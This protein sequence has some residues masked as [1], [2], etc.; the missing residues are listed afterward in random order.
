METIVQYSEKK[1]RVPEV[2]RFCIDRKKLNRLFD[3]TRE[4]AVIVSGKAGSGKTNAMAQ[5]CR[6]KDV[7]WYTFDLSDNEEE[8]FSNNFLLRVMSELDERKDRERNGSCCLVMDEF[9]TVTNPNVLNNIQ[10]LLEYA[11]GKFRIFILTSSYMQSCFSKFVIEGRYKKITEEHLRF[12]LGEIGELAEKYFE[13]KQ[14]RQEYLQKIEKLTQGW[15]VAVRCLLQ[16]MEGAE[17]IS[18]VMEMTA[19]HL[20]METILYDYIYY[21]IYEKFSHDEQDFL[22]KTAGLYELEAVLCD[23]CLD[24]EDSG[25]RLHNFMRKYMLYTVWE[26]EGRYFR[27]FELFQIFLLEQGGKKQQR[28]MEQLAT[29]FYLKEQRYDKAVYHAG[30]TEEQIKRIFDEYGKKMLQDGKLDLIE[31]CIDVLQRKGHEFSVIGLEIAAEY[32]YRTGNHEQMERCLNCADSMF[33]KENKYGMYRSLYRALFHY[34]E[35][36]ERYAKQINEVLFFLEENKILL[37]Y[38]LEPDKKTLNRIM[39]ERELQLQNHAEKKIKVSAFGTFRVVILEDGKELSWRTRK[40]CELFAYL[41]DRNGEAVERKT[42]LSELWKEELPNNA[43]A[44]LHN[45]FYNIRKE[46]S[47]YN[48]E[49]IIQYKNKKY[50]MDV[51]VIESDLCEMKNA[52]GCVEKKK[53]EKLKEYKDLFWTYRG[54]YLEDIDN[55]WAREKQEY[56]EKIF[57][58]GCCMLAEKC[59]EQGEYEEALVYLK[60]ALAVSIYSENIVSMMLQCYHKTGDLKSAKKQYESFVL[61]LKKELD[62]EPGVE[63]QKNYRKCM[64]RNG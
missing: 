45:M 58:K 12:S 9:Q 52:A 8:N 30:D 1:W 60:N 56:Y 55:E 14:V 24:R 10:R 64:I 49:H 36:Q 44:M 62:V 2:S 63:V 40:G 32:F 35:S 19:Y 18:K 53:K 15:A 43:V 6:G 50:Q 23:D 39:A 20:L 57:E 33:G 3:D 27:Y 21:E 28:E 25:K 37:P 5:Y 61:L 22:I 13:K 16:T 34:E 11:S 59:M 41:L 7:L 42:L 17:N 51:S 38:L 47:Y 46:L 4:Q 31:H 26:G 48:L 54:R 29:E